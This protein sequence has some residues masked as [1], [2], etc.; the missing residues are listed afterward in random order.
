MP[1]NLY[2]LRAAGIWAVSALT[3]ACGATR[4]SEWTDAG[5]EWDAHSDAQELGD[6][7]ALCV[8]C[9][10]TAILGPCNDTYSACSQIDECVT[11]AECAVQT[12]CFEGLPLDVENCISKRCPDGMQFMDLWW[13]SVMCATCSIGCAKACEHFACHE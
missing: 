10:S 3:T 9:Y 11:F 7:P 4:P 1:K 8:N 2:V 5:T 13:P 6:A 12:E